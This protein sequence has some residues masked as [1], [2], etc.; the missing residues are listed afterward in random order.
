M[1]KLGIAVFILTLIVAA[2]AAVME[3]AYPPG[4]KVSGFMEES[5]N[6]GC[7]F[8]LSDYRGGLHGGPCGIGEAVNWGYDVFLTGAGDE[9]PFESVD[10]EPV[11]LSGDERPTSGQVILDRSNNLV[12]I[13]LKVRRGTNLVDFK[14]NGTFKINRAP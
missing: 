8:Q 3:R 5:S 9:F 12:T 10:V 2:L 4:I 6:N 1:R 13:D 14:G 7:L 11:R